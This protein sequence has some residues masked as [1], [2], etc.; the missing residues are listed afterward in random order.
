LLYVTHLLELLQDARVQILVHISVLERILGGLLGGRDGGIEVLKLFSKPHA[1]LEWISHCV[2][3]A[4]GD[5]KLCCAPPDE[6]AV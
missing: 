6:V 3:G 1:D 4:L 2:V 5:G